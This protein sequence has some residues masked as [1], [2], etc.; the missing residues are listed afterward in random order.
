MQHFLS[1]NSR[2]Q[3]SYPPYLDKMS[4]VIRQ[5]L[6][7]HSRLLV[8]R[9][10]LWSDI[11]TL[12]NRRRDL[13][14]CFIESLGTSL[15]E[16]AWGAN[17][18]PIKP[19]FLWTSDELRPFYHAVVFLDQDMAW[20]S[21]PTHARIPVL[22]SLLRGAWIKTLGLSDAPI[23]GPVYERT[24]DG[25]FLLDESDT[26]IQE[27]I[28]RLTWHLSDMVRDRRGVASPEARAL[29]SSAW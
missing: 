29:E 6:K 15:S 22:D 10:E 16:K 5:A 21:L 17:T 8:V 13:S 24:R 9:M 26:F 7:S 11:D 27:E 3:P 12:V 1:L 19:D 25:I 2:Y 28:N 4:S 18:P 23:T 14:R 20:N